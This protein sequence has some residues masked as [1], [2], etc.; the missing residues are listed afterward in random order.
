MS[1]GRPTDASAARPRGGVV[2]LG[3]AALLTGCGTLITPEP[4]DDAAFATTIGGLHQE[5]RVDTVPVNAAVSVNGR[6]LGFAPVTV[7]LEVDR[8][9][10][11][12][13]DVTLSA[14]FPGGEV[15]S[16]QFGRGS[17]PPSAVSLRSGGSSSYLGR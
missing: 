4:D 13:D 11:L 10:D 2:A 3:L 17:K 9:G 8:N 15:E 14:D 1:T 16:Q 7:R 5:V 12:V 6:M